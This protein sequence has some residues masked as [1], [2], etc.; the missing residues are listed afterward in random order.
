MKLLRIIYEWPPPWIGLT[1][2]PYELTKAQATL[3]YEITLFCGRWPRA[4]LVEHLDGVN[5]ISFWREPIR[6][7]VLVTTAPIMSLY[8]LY[9]RFFHDVEIY[10]VHG[11]FGFY[12][13][14]YKLLF[15]FLDKTPLVVHFH[16][17]IKG[18]WVDAQ[19]KEKKISL[20]SRFFDW[21]LSQ[22]AEKL[23]VK[24]ADF[25]V[26]VSHNVKDEIKTYY[27]IDDSKCRV[28]ETAVNTD[29]FKPTFDDLKKE[30]K[31]SL[32]FKEED[33]L[34]SNIGYLVERKNIHLLIEALS[35]LPEYYKLMLVGKVEPGYQEI[36]D[37]K[38]NELFLKDRVVFMGEKNYPDTPWY[39]RGSDVFVLPSSYEGFPKVVLEALACGIPVIASGFKMPK[40]RGLTE[41]K[42]ITP[43]EIANA[44]ELVI[45]SKE[46]CDVEQIENNFSWGVRSKELDKI[47]RQ[48]LSKD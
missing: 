29:L 40:V 38:I 6:G 20:I 44:I 9:W 23:A 8:F 10:H 41:L 14:I 30:I 13:Y 35:V 4:G 21:P 12:I 16:N 2:H 34:V 33:I 39:Y 27:G 22:L 46:V 42:A 17:S 1:P 24:A 7:L 31:L 18:R 3:G 45:S 47:Y 36:L 25:C 28:L 43:S 11:A 48:L 37:E 15:G 5:L 26:F 19:I 32:G